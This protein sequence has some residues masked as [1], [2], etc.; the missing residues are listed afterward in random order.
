MINKMQ[1]FNFKQVPVRVVER[2]GKPWFVAADVCQILEFANTCD[3][4]SDL[5]ENEEM[6]A[7]V[8]ISGLAKKILIISESGLYALIFKS[9]NPQAKVFLKW[10]MEDVLPVIRKLGCA[11]SGCD[12]VQ[13][14]LE[15]AIVEVYEGRFSREKV[16]AIASLANLFYRNESKHNRMTMNVQSDEMREFAGLVAVLWAKDQ[17]REWKSCEMREIALA[18]G[19]FSSWLTRKSVYGPSAGSRF[20]LLC[21][22]FNGNVF[23]GIRF[24]RHGKNRHRYFMLRKNK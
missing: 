15:Q 17:M 18:E 16:D 4:V 21:D 5:E 22:S 23:E 1:Q 3:A 20:G 7:I 19:L 6:D 13:W 11:V 2:D 10:I 12:R 8:E 9:R 24:E 14:I